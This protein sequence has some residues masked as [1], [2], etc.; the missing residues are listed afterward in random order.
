MVSDQDRISNNLNKLI[1]FMEH[2][3]MIHIDLLNKTFYNGKIVRKVEDGVFIIDDKVLGE[4]HIFLNEIY[5]VDTYR[6]NNKEKPKFN[7]F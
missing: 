1:F 7:N 6:E 5:K 2:D 4:Q 3:M